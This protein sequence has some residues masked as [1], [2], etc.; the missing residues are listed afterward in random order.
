MKTYHLTRGLLAS[1][2]TCSSA[3]PLLL[4]LG[5]A[6]PSTARVLPTGYPATQSNQTA[7]VPADGIRM[8]SPTDLLTKVR[9]S[10]EQVFAN[11]INFVCSEQIDRFRGSAHNPSGHK[12][13]VITSKVSYTNDAEHYSDIH[14][15]N[16]PLSQIGGLSGAWSE[17][18]YGTVLSD[19]V[20]AL[21]SRTI[22]FVSFSMLEG[23]TA[24][25]YRFDYSA[26][27]SPWDIAVSGSHYSLPFHGQIWVS[28]ATGD[29]LRIDRIAYDVPV[30]TGI[31][32][33]NWA[34]MFGPTTADGKTFWLPS[35]GVYSVSYLNSDRHE[36]NE[37]A[38]SDY[39]HFGSDVVVH[40]R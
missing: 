36:W 37:L 19:T 11:L 17:G 29:I 15:N 24:A 18:E 7:N 3:L 34:V 5:I 27:D 23:K 2:R 26:A 38:F 8:P 31:S 35:K 25:V 21:R 28:P 6:K 33:V 20:K 22:K 30:Q 9:A 16:K 1:A 39:K 40:F 4:V 12:I 32:G 14:Q 13:D 10:A